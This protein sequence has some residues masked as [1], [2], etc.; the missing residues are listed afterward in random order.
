MVL[1]CSKIASA[2]P[3]QILSESVFISCLHVMTDC[4]VTLRASFSAI[5]FTNF[6]SEGS[7]RLS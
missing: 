4:A 3:V 7:A 1:G 6:L 2:S 5:S